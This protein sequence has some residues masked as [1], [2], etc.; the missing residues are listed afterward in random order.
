MEQ[1]PMVKRLQEQEED[2]IVKRLVQQYLEKKEE[3]PVVKTLQRQVLML[4]GVV[5]AVA[6][7]LAV[8][9]EDYGQVTYYFSSW[10]EW[11]HRYALS[12]IERI[13]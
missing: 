4:L 8:Y 1:D 9:I 2:P 10:I 12:I 13:Y 7:A 6:V 3:D 11:G 5:G